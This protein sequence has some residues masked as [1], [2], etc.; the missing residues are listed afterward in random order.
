[1][2]YFG[3]PKKTNT[4]DK[5]VAEKKSQQN[6][7]L[8]TEI[9]L[10][11]NALS[12]PDSSGKVVS[13]TIGK[14]LENSSGKIIAPTFASDIVFKIQLGAF[15][16]E[17]PL[18]IVNQFLKISKLGVENH[19]DLNGLTIFTAG[20]FKTYGE[21]SK[22]KQEVIFNNFKDAFIVAYRNGKKIA[23]DEAKIEY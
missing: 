18:E 17:V 8:K 12:I 5:I 11:K 20:D 7:N 9:P 2:P 15:K 16:N 22:I 4:L 21:A 3:L 23:I 6:L 13:S 1:L 10:D 19:K 14:Q